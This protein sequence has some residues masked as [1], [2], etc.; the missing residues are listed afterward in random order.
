VGNQ[1]GEGQSK[2]GYVRS[3]GW[4]QNIRSLERMLSAINLIYADVLNKGWV[5]RR[6]GEQ[7]FRRGGGEV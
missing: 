5:P 2:R 1:A 6:E 7:G 3:K 4:Y